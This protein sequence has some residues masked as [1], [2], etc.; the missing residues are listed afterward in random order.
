MITAVAKQRRLATIA[1]TSGKGGV[2]KTNVVV[3]VAVAMARLGHRVAILDADFGL[4]NVDVLLGLAPQLHLGSVLAGDAALADILVQGPLG[5]QVIPSSSGIRALTA[6][7]PAHWERLQR[8]L[9]DIAEFADFLIIDT[10]S[11]ISDN[12]I[13]LLGLAQRVL[14]V[15]ALEPTA[16]V[17]AYAVIK[18]LSTSSPQREIGL[19][20][21]SA[22]DAT[23]AQLVF[24]QLQVAAQRFLKRRLVYYGFIAHDPAVREAVLMQ[25][26]IVD[27]Q[28]QAS[29]SRCF[30]ML[31][32]R[33]SST[34]AEDRS[35]RLVPRPAAASG[36][37]V[38]QCG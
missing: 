18:L 33:L 6:L 15:T 5:V 24:A 26:P 25:R 1:V 7:T 28:P 3:N 22:R 21:N 27:H 2:G 29:A 17:D 34:P 14:V 32:T 10:A 4:G 30:R 12:V 19:L 35:L 8:V 16:V 31:A 38:P 20:V 37:R 11:G 36:A 13:E 9:D 23:D